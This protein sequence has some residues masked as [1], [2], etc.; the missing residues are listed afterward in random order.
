[1]LKNDYKLFCNGGGEK[2]SPREKDKETK[3]KS[4]K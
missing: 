4:Q 1:M 2:R 3:H